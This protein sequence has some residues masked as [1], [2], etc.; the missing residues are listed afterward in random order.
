MC[1]VYLTQPLKLKTR[2]SEEMVIYDINGNELVS[3]ASGGSPI[4]GKKILM[5]GDSNMQYSGDGI[6]EYIENT[7][8]CSF[9][10]LAKAGVGWEYTGTDV[11]TS[12]EVTTSC[13]VGYVNQIISTAN[14]SNIIT[15][16]DKIVIMLGT[17]CY[18]LGT[19]TD[20]ADQFDTMCGAIRY[21]LETLCYYGRQI[22]IGVIIPIRCDE[23]Y[24]ISATMGSMP[25]KF[26]LLEELA[27]QYSIPTL[28][29][30]DSGRVIPN[31]YT[32]DGTSYYLGDSVHLGAN[33]NIQFQHIL[34]QWLAFQL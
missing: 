11:S 33:G 17:N 15:A 6:K 29:M 4:A 19:I 1:Q 7:Y 32:P 34:G 8:G 9:A 13:G 5:I 31:G 3:S 26:K 22:A 18:N 21:C 27:R 10:V 12:E 16:Y 28:N 25:E 30:W 23:N 20:T 14:E 2:G 24:N